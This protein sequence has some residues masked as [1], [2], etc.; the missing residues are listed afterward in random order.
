MRTA[1]WNEKQEE[2]KTLH[3]TVSIYCEFQV[4]VTSHLDEPLARFIYYLSG[5]I[6]AEP[7]RKRDASPA[8]ALPEGFGTA[9]KA[10]H[11]L[12]ALGVTLGQKWTD[13]LE[14]HPASDRGTYAFVICLR[15]MFFESVGYH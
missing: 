13:G 12:S 4:A 7:P 11:T 14:P 2:R 9:A 8:L 1:A 10:F 3:T 5:G 6:F 15:M